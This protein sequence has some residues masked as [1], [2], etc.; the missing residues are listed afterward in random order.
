MNRNRILLVGAVALILL[1]TGVKLYANSKAR[2]EVDEA[3]EKA[4]RY[5][6][7]EYGN[8]KGKIFN[9]SAVINDVKIAPTVGSGVQEVQKEIKVD[10][11]EVG[12]SGF[13]EE[14]VLKSLSISFQ[15]IEMDTEDMDPQDRQIMRDL[16]YEGVMRVNLEVDFDYQKKEERLSVHDVSFGIDELGELALGMDLGNIKLDE[17]GLVSLLF[18][19]PQ[20][21]MS[22]LQIAYEDDSFLPRLMEYGAKQEGMSTDEFK[23]RLAS[24]IEKEIRAADTKFAKES[25]EKLQEFVQEPKRISISASPDEP[26]SVGKIMRIQEPDD[27]I[28]VLK[29]RVKL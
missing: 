13:N 1:I 7:I 19:Y 12:G 9:G 17:N 26:Q 21:L 4:S 14:D 20:I 16:G 2:S 28:E 11:I 18:T 24:N 23:K 22:D 29:I 27:L 10:R 25:L 6:E 3:V 15:G 8:V 5:A